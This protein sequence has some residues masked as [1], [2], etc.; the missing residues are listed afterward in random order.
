MQLVMIWAIPIVWTHQFRPPCLSSCRNSGNAPKCILVTV[1]TA[2]FGLI[3]SLVRDPWPTSSMH[4]SLIADD[5]T[6]QLPPPGLV[7]NGS[8]S[9]TRAFLRLQLR[10]SISC[11]RR[12]LVH[13]LLLVWWIGERWALPCTNSPPQGRV[14]CVAYG[15]TTYQ[16]LRGLHLA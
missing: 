15:M 5:P 9:F 14:L 10:S 16:R 11:N 2:A 7:I 3:T 8:S 13:N 1:Q 6:S 4:S 12:S